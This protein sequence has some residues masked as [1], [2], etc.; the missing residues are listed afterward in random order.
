M[1][2]LRYISKLLSLLLL[3][4]LYEIVTRATI[5]IELFYKMKFEICVKF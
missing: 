2:N 1:S 3:L 4:S 5:Y